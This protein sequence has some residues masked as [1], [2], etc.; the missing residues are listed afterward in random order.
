M[1]PI[2]LRGRLAQLVPAAV[3][4]SACGVALGAQT[5]SRPMVAEDLFALKE[6]GEIRISPDGATVLFTVS[7]TDRQGGRSSQ[8]LRLPAAGG[9]PAAVAGALE[10][11]SSVRWSPDGTRIAFFA[12]KS[13]KPALWV[14]RLSTREPTLVCDHERLSALIAKP[15]NSLA[16]SPDGS[17]LAFTGTTEPPPGFQDPLVIRRIQ[18]KTSTAFSDNGRSHIYVVSAAGGRPRAVTSGNYDEHSID[19]GGN[20]EEIIFLS[21]READPDANFNYDIFAVN[22]GS[23]ATRQITRTPGVE[24]EPKVSPDGRQIAYLGMKRPLTTIDSIAEDAHV[25]VIPAAGGV[26]RELNGSLDRRSGSPE[27]APDGKAIV[28]TAIDHANTVLYRVPAGGGRS[29]ILVDRQGQAGPF[30]IDR[31]GSI[32][33]GLSDPLMPREIFRLRAGSTRSEQLTAMN[34][35]VKQWQLSA[36]QTITFRSFDGTEI[37]GWLYPAAQATGRSPMILFIHGGPHNINAYSFNFGFQYNSARGY[38]TL[39]INPR[40]STGSGQKFSDGCINNWGGGDYKDLMAGIDYVLKTH[41]EIDGSRLGVTGGSYGG[42][43]TNW[44]ITQTNRFKAA[45]SHR[46]ISNLISFYGT[47]AVGDLM[48]TEFNGYPWNGENFALLWKWSPLAH[49]KNTVTPTMFIHGEIDN[50]C[51]I[52]QAEEMYTALRRRGIPAE[53]VRYPREGHGLREPK[54]QMD[55]MLR[56]LEWMD[57]FLKGEGRAFRQ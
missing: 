34:H 27:W 41:P 18:F 4:I 14:L 33:F 29:V 51:P 54:H 47:S 45:V 2:K 15:G 46:S 24:L 22:V 50:I 3:I 42:F 43:M 57:H 21:N 7:T 53:L 40:G 36:P 48:H 20:G 37:E 56:G 9:Q 12:G 44:I 13:G 52:T 23:G 17:Q 11:A 16:W 5:G 25:W 35:E 38:A 10:G 49:V 28:Y 31:E 6:I 26:G 55:G 32:V 19:W 8:L 1:T 30:S 39:A